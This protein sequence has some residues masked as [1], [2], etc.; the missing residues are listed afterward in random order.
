MTLVRPVTKAKLL[1]S[2]HR[3]NTRLPTAVKRAEETMW[4]HLAIR[5][6]HRPA[7][8]PFGKYYKTLTLFAPLKLLVVSICYNFSVWGK[9]VITM[10]KTFSMTHRYKKFLQNKACLSLLSFSYSVPSVVLNQL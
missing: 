4:S 1:F 7:S 2:S 5:G 10:C 6:H 3:G 8:L 9:L